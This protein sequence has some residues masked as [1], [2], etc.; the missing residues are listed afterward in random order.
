[1]RYITNPD[2]NSCEFALVISDT[3]QGHGI[4]Q[5]MLNRLMEIARSRGL[6][7]IEG[8]VLADNHRMLEMVRK[9]GFHIQMAADDPSIRD[10]S[11]N[12]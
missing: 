9:M 8:E 2:Q 10:V 6:D 12:L 1:M 4:G 3:L 7:M 5:R 11:K